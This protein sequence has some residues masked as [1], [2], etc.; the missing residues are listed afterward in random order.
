MR[1]AQ[2]DIIQAVRTA[3]MAQRERPMIK[4]ILA[5]AGIL[6]CLAAIPASAACSQADMTGKWDLYTNEP[7]YKSTGATWTKCLVTID[8]TG[9]IVPHS[10][11]QPGIGGYGALTGNITFSYSCMF[12]GTLNALLHPTTI[13]QSTLSKDKDVL[14]GVTNHDNQGYL[15]TMI[16]VE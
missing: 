8:G 12:A 1:T 2:S 9:K 3:P 13:A 7:L 4:T 15:F 10:Y 16:K 6:G 14:S 5:S 11:C